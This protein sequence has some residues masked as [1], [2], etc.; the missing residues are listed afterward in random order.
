[1]KKTFIFLGTGASAGVPVV[2]CCCAVCRSSSPFNQRLRSSLLIRFGQRQFLIDAG[3]DFRMQA[4]RFSI[5]FLDGLLLTHS[6]HDHT[7]G[8]D[9]LRPLFHKRHAPIPLL[10]SSQTAQ[11]IRKS[12]FYL[13]KTPP[14]FS[15]QLLPEQETGEVSF[16]GVP[17]QFV[18]Y[19]QGKMVVNGYRLGHFAYLS[20]IKEFSPSIFK[21]LEGV[22]CLIIS[23]LKRVPSPL[24][25]S[26]DEAIDF[27]R[28]VGAEQIW[29][30]H[31]SHDLDYEQ[32]NAYLPSN[33][34]LAYDGLEIE[35][36]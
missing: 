1:M 26:V 25:L 17:F 33:I 34:R 35:M 19:A 36:D 30:T 13:F 6:H 16:E 11:E 31:L 14:L 28:K 8:L 15:L 3:P 21:S 29:L 18:T 10:L 23:A 2:G 24:H 22:K 27:G 5:C 4:L 20:D 7:A 32:T 9:D 12:Y